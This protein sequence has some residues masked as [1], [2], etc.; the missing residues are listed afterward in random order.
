MAE[1]SGINCDGTAVLRAFPDDTDQPLSG[2]QNIR[3]G[4][5][6]RG[7]PMPRQQ[8]TNFLRQDAR[9]SC[10]VSQLRDFGHAMIATLD[11]RVPTDPLD[12]PR[13]ASRLWRSACFL[14]QRQP[15]DAVRHRSTHQAPRSPTEP[16]NL[17]PANRLKRRS[18][19]RQRVSSEGRAAVNGARL[20]RYRRTPAE[21]NLHASLP[22]LGS[23][24]RFR[25]F[26]DRSNSRFKTVSC[27][28]SS[29]LWSKTSCAQTSRL[30]CT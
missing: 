11:H 8:L 5:P 26:H 6:R 29:N 14:E 12:G 20:Q 18:N 23:L 9:G 19:A 1:L 24:S 15:E 13:H 28:S 7:G 17:S 4:V 2:A 30:R 27:K 3:P 22:L 10:V 21:A 25:E 16:T